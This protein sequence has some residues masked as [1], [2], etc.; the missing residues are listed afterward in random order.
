[1]HTLLPASSFSR[2]DGRRSLDVGGW[3]DVG[4]VG[5]EFDCFFASFS[6]SDASVYLLA[7]FRNLSANDNELALSISN[8]V[9]CLLAP[10]ASAFVMDVV[11][12]LSFL[13]SSVMPNDAMTLSAERMSP[14]IGLD[15]FAVSACV[16]AA[17]STAFFEKLKLICTLFG[18]SF[19]ETLSESVFFVVIVGCVDAGGSDG[20]GGTLIV[21]D[22][23]VFVVPWVPV[24]DSVGIVNVAVLVS[25]FDGAVIVYEA[26]TASDDDDDDVV[27]G[28]DFDGETLDDTLASAGDLIDGTRSLMVLAAD[29]VVVV[30]VDGAVLVA[31]FSF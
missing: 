6:L 27:G 15:A 24:G 17:F 4:D 5:F 18:D 10:L 30:A 16:F 21:A 14:S 19:G 3:Y 22:A 20:D 23:D 9:R 11:L 7:S 26:T 31:E 1:M 29:V 28:S 13:S 12:I 25:A 2:H 8:N